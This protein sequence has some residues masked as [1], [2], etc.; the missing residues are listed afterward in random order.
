VS[1]RD[2]LIEQAYHEPIQP[3]K[4]REPAK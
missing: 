4:P 3:P 1:E 2:D